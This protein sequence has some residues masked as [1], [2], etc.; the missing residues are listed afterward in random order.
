MA[1]YQRAGVMETWQINHDD[2]GHYLIGPELGNNM[3]M[4]FNPD[5]ARLFAAAPAMLA[6]LEE[7]LEIVS[8]PPTTGTA[9]MQAKAKKILSWVTDAR[10]TIAKAGNK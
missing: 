6:A 8:G 7:A 2:K 4:A 3:G 5:A 9:A 1:D 10:A